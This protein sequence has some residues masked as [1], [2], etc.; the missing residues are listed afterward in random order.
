[1]RNLLLN[2]RVFLQATEQVILQV[3]KKN[4]NE[5]IK[6]SNI[7]KSINITKKKLKYLVKTSSIYGYSLSSYTKK[8][9]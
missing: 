6:I 9:N 5:K 3:Y 7:Y 4:K 1:M 8:H 2:F